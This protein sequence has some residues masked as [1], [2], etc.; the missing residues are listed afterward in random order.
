MEKVTD[1]WFVAQGEGCRLLTWPVAGALAQAMQLAERAAQLIAVLQS[2]AVQAL[3]SRAIAKHLGR[4]SR[5]EEHLCLLG[6]KRSF[7]HFGLVGKRCG[8][9]AESSE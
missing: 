6:S 5:L 1:Y 8:L 7:P 2:H 9:D 3:I 4:K